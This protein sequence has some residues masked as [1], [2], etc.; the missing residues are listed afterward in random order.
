MGNDKVNHEQPFRSKSK[1]NGQT[2][3]KIM[4]FKVQ[5]SFLLILSS[6]GL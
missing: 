6:V 2:V 4:T 1:S 5:H 3:A